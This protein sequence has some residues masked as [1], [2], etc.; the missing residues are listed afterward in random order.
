MSSLRDVAMIGDCERSKTECGAGTQG[1]RLGAG[2]PN[3]PQA[4]KKR[5]VLPRS[6]RRA[7]ND[8][9]H[10]MEQRLVEPPV[11]GF[12]PNTGRAHQGNEGDLAHYKHG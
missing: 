10:G 7:R 4:N 1:S 6:K 2:P 5:G 11:D 8:G 3:I 9:P 12:P